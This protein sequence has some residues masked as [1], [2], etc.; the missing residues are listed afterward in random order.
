M[1][2]QTPLNRRR[3]FFFHNDYL[4]IF[5]IALITAAVIFLPFVI[6]DRGYFLYYGDFNVQ[7]IP[8]YLTAHDKVQSGDI[9][10]DWGTDLGANFI[11]SYTFYLLTSP[12]FWLTL[13]FP[14]GV[15]PFLMAPLLVLK[16]ACA[17]VTGFAFLKRFTANSQYAVIGALLYA[18]CGFNQFNIFFNHFHEAVIVFPLL[19]VALEEFVVNGRRG[20]FAIA[21]AGC[22]V[23]NY[24]FFFGQVTFTLIYFFLRCF[25]PDFRMNAKR[26]LLLVFEAVLG[27][28]LACAV[29]L[30]SALAI[31][32]NPRTSSTYTG[33][34]LLLYGNVQ[35]YGLI[36]ESLFFPPDIPS[37]PNFFP[38]SNAKWSS[39]SAWLPLFSMSGVA[40]FCRW[41][42]KHWL[43]RILLV[44]GVMALVPVLNSSFYAF[45]SSY[46]ARWYY[47]PVLMM[48]LATCLAL[49]DV[50]MDFSFGIKFC[51]VMVAA[52][53]VIGIIPTEDE[54]GVLRW[55]SSPPYPERFWAY[56]LIAVLSILLLWV[57]YYQIR[58]S[59]AFFRQAAAFVCIISV[60]STMLVIGTG[61]QHSAVNVYEQVVEQGINGKENFD[62]ETDVFYRVDEYELLD[63]MPMFWDMPTIQCFHSIVPA[64]IMEFYEAIGVERDVASRPGLS[65]Y[66]LRALT[67]VKYLFADVDEEEQPSL[68]GFTWIGEQNGLNVYENQYFI[69]MGFTYD[70]YVPESAQEDYLPTSL[71]KLMLK[72]VMLSDEDAEQHSDI[73]QELP[74]GLYPA[75]SEEEYYQ[76]CQDRA[77]TAAESFDW[78]THGFT[79]QITLERENLVFFSVPYEAGWT[80]YVNGEEAE[81]VRANIG[82]MAVRAPEGENVIEFKYRT[83]GLYE[84]MAVSGT[85]LILLGGYLLLVRRWRKRHPQ[86]RVRPHRHRLPYAQLP[87][88]R[89]EAAYI[90]SV[91]EQTGRRGTPP[92]KPEDK[93]EKS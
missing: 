83:P 49:Q 65:Y 13:L 45:N 74:D 90:R 36:L 39:V 38:D 54:D 72:A 16:F 25:S 88:V 43:K 91:L 28:L 79:A 30:P 40:V 9:F 61:K 23:I 18:F 24:F 19:L 32:D 60:I 64:S 11:G 8:F 21:V 56:I 17:G 20:C 84:G 3:I 73:L 12:F 77:A 37:R 80:A 15:V 50:K 93:T 92:E 22:A 67:S 63:N 26:F 78:D 75:M 51:T 44:C 57:L 86:D 29:L 68:Y 62:L 66:G 5:V 47:M 76:D 35:R 6:Y 27:V 55:F 48:C 42:K 10:W 81:I 14:S 59:R 89:A 58:R 85:A 31:I 87:P 69:P 70:Y 33:M 52:F 46:Y 34:N 71:D 7:Q 82:F 2:E 41:A 4:N 1:M 53:A